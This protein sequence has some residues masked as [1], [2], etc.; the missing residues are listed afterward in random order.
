MVPIFSLAFIWFIRNVLRSLFFLE[1][2]YTICLLIMRCSL[3]PV[4]GR[5]ILKVLKFVL[6]DKNVIK[7][8][9]R[10]LFSC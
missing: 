6:S 9:C 5:Q 8:Q 1:G 10:D 2:N 4:R 3:T 7:V